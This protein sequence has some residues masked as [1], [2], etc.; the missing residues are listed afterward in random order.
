MN[1]VHPANTYETALLQ[2]MKSAVSC[3]RGSIIHRHRPSVPVILQAP[4][5]VIYTGLVHDT[6]SLIGTFGSGTIQQTRSYRRRGERALNYA[7]R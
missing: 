6:P 1:K 5:A 7:F 2:P 4:V 3:S